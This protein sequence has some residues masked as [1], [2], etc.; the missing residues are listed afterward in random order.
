LS[1]PTAIIIGQ[2]GRLV[3]LPFLF[4]LGLA[5][6]S[7]AAEEVR[8]LWVVRHDINTSERVDSVV[9]HAVN[10]GINTLFVQVRGRGD[11]YYHSE[12]VSEGEQVESGFD[13]LAACLSRAHDASIEVH[14]WM[15]VYLT[16]YPNRPASQTHLL[17]RH[18]DWFM[19][20]ADGVD[21]GQAALDVDLVDRGVEG[22]YLSP[23]NPAA[24]SHLLRVIAEVLDAYPVDGIHLDYVR[25]PNEHY[26]YSPLAQSS[27]WAETEM[28]PPRSQSSD[29]ELRVW[30][31]WRSGLITDFV[32]RAKHLISQRR[33]SARLSA[34][35]KPEPTSAYQRH[36]QDW[37]YWVNRR[38][39]DFAVPMFYTGSREDIQARMQVVRKYVQRGRIYAGIGAW[40]QSAKETFE[41]IELM[42]KSK[43][44]GFSLF[45][46][47]TLRSSPDLQRGLSDRFGSSSP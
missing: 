33:P 21:H 25:Y 46:Y 29:S 6:N 43:L 5:V 23:A 3:W 8:A 42:R 10:A 14:A 15:N 45:S 4:L 36:G 7:V 1:L 31:R 38:Y 22:R 28:D 30:R 11:A 37:V 9:E 47:A 35:V 40:N 27:L 17:A 12:F 20:S 19:I 34:A 44:N 13:P 18:P 26:D 39:L 16:W 32:R 24:Q 41:Q 2:S